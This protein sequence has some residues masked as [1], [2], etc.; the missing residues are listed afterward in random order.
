MNQKEILQFIQNRPKNLHGF[1]DWFRTDTHEILTRGIRV[2][3][4]RIYRVVWHDSS[5]REFIQYEVECE[6][7]RRHHDG[8]IEWFQNGYAMG[9]FP[10]D[11][12]RGNR[13]YRKAKRHVNQLSKT[14]AKRAKRQLSEEL[15]SKKWTLLVQ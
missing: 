6:T 13:S 14:W 9:V 15:Q 5:G 12:R 7:G 11:D 3:R 4:L 8:R 10:H 2:K 1:D